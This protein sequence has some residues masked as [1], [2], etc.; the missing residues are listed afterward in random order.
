VEA[1]FTERTA[2]KLL[3]EHDQKVIEDQMSW[4][5]LRAP[6]RSPAGLLR[7]AIEKNWPK[8]AE[9]WTSKVFESDGWQFARHFYAAYGGNRGEPVTDP[10]PREAEAADAFV[11]R[12]L[13]VLPGESC[14]EEWGRDLGRMARAQ[15]HPFPS[16][17][18]AI[19]QLGD[20]LLT[21]AQNDRLN[22]QL[23][24][25][26][27]AREAHATEYRPAWMSWLRE[28][29]LREKNSHP[30]DYSRFLAKREMER[31]ELA[32]NRSPWAESART[33]FDS[34]SAR[35]QAFRQ[36]FGLPDFWGWD[37]EF[38]SNQF[39]LSTNQT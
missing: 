10:S 36:F 19:R 37:A 3:R 14:V 15:R 33:S 11:K 20:G 24:R 12:L 23:E 17:S 27:K 32:A 39:N 30:A 21:K 8:P 16:L 9:L 1:G 7:R 38:N 5:P 2:L 34:E 29:E 28:Q 4:L 18:L 6:A 26:A 25:T 35:L 31:I 22:A 13:S